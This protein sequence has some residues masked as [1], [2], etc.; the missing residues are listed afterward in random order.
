MLWVTLAWGACFVAIRWGLRDAPVLWFAGLRAG[1][2][3]V[4]L[5]TVARWQHRPP[6][7]GARSW[8]LV[9]LLGAVNATIA[10]AA[11]FAGVAGLATGT[12]AVLANA[13]PLLILLPAWW[14]YGEAI[15]ARIAVGLVAGF[16]GLLVVALPGGGGSGAA[17]SMLSA[18]AITAG[19]LLARRLGAL[20]LVVASGWHFLLGGTALFV[21]AAAVEGWPGIDW[22]PRFVAV[23][24]FLSLVGTAAAYLAWFAESRRCPLGLLAAWTFL[25]PVAGVAFAAVLLDEAPDGWTAAGIALVLGS[26]WVVLHPRRDSSPARTATVPSSTEM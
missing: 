13:Q 26:L 20:D 24:G 14:L 5:L 8:S 21:W 11:M 7:R 9:S 6:I 23:L 17:L 12:A 4:A 2:A 19:T 18:T 22:T 10:F 16:A 3:G 25:V 15:S 1:V